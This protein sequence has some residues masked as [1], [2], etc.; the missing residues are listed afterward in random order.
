M[1]LWIAKS[2]LCWD[3]LVEDSVEDDRQAQSEVIDRVHP[4]VVH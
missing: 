2:K 4:R 3:V 1:N